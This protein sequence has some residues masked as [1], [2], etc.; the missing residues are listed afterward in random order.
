VSEREP[1][2]HAVVIL[3]CPDCGSNF[4][5]AAPLELFEQLEA[6]GIAPEEVQAAILAGLDMRRILCE[7]CRRGALN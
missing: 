4:P 3:T 6:A 5:A 1:K 2:F 7:G